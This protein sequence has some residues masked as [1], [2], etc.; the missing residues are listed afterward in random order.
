MQPS[1][2]NGNTITRLSP[3]LATARTGERKSKE[4]EESKMRLFVEIEPID[5]VSVRCSYD[6]AMTAGILLGFLCA[7]D[8]A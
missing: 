3:L 1:F 2:E 7:F 4:S 6:Y 8:L 5:R